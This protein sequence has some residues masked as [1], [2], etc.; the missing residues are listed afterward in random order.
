MLMTK[1]VTLKCDI[2]RQETTRIIGKLHFIPINGLSRSA[3]SNYTHHAD[4]G[5]CCKDRL[6]KGF[7]FRKRMS[8]EQY[9]E[10]RKKNGQAAVKTKT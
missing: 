5:E 9:Q 2:C 1:L 10:A 6:L 7:S 4:V 8:R 3:H